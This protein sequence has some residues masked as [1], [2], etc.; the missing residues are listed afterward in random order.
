[1]TIP[2]SSSGRTPVFETGNLGSNPSPGAIRE[3]GALIEADEPSILS[4]E[5]RAQRREDGGLRVWSETLPGLILSGSDPASVWRD[6]GP[7]IAILLKRNGR[8]P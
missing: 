1:M 3:D 4:I 7:A 8:I 5:L 2:G 6:V